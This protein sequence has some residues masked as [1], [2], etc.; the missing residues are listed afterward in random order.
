LS[1]LAAQKTTNMK[2]IKYLFFLLLLTI[3]GGAVFIATKDGKF[4]IEENRI[5]NA[6][7][8]LLFDTVNEFK[9]WEEWGPWMDISDDLVMNYAEQTSG[10]GS[11]YNWS[12]ETQGDGSMKTIK[13]IP[14]TNIDQN[15]T[16]VTPMGETNNKVYWKFEKLEGKKTKVTWGMKGEQSFMEKAFWMTQDS[17][18][19]QNLIPM[20]QKGL[21]KLDHYA[22]KKMKE[23]AI[24]IDGEVEHGGGFYMYTATASSIPSIPQKMEQMFPLVTEYIRQNNLPQTGMPFTVYNEFNQ[25]QNT[26]IYST[27]IP[28]REKVITP[29]DSNIL[30][31]FLPRQKTIKVTLKGDYANL[32]EAWMA[33][34]KH[35]TK[36]GLEAE[37]TSAP[38]EIYKTAAT[39]QANPAK[40]MTDIYIPIK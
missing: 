13:T 29:S 27:G 26:A 22:H 32:K 11:S 31:G 20:Y 36:N 35:I 18:L 14:F 10:E 24:H 6:P 21:K 12:S 5:I 19:S 39:I 16:L 30:C 23:Y 9:T 34:Y 15:I 38:F 28:I 40:W 37:T 3:I 17:T 4:Q 2:V 25:E 7:D 1:I 8:E 33:G